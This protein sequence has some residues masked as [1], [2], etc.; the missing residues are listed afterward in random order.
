[1]KLSL[2]ALVATAVIGVH[3]HCWCT[4]DYKYSEH[5]TKKACRKFGNYDLGQDDPAECHQYLIDKHGKEDWKQKCRNAG[6]HT[7]T[8]ED[9]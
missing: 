5:Y 9:W 8:C 3:S 6:A 1:M 4:V 2:F 7:G